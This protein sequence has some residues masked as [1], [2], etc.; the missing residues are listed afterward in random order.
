MYAEEAIEEGVLD[1]LR[2]GRHL[3]HEL[4]GLKLSS[5]DH[6]ERKVVLKIQTLGLLK[7]TE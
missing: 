1:G 2:W 5:K 7:D 3:T 4:R 6:Q